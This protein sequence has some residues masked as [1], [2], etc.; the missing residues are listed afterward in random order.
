MYLN[1]LKNVISSNLNWTGNF[2]LDKN[3]ALINTGSVLNIWGTVGRIT[4]L[5]VFQ[6]YV[7]MTFLTGILT[8]LCMYS[9]VKLVIKDS[10]LSLIVTVL[11]YLIIIKDSIGRPSPTQLT[12]WIVFILITIIYKQSIMYKKSSF[13]LVISLYLILILSNP[14]YAIFILIYFTFLIVLRYKKSSPLLILNY[15]FIVSLSLIYYLNLE[16]SVKYN[17]MLIRFGIL[18]D[19]FPGAFNLTITLLILSLILMRLILKRQDE[20]YNF[21]FVLIIS[22]L[23]S[24]NSQILTGVFFEAESHFSYLVKTVIAISLVY[25]LNVTKF[26]KL[27]P[28]LL[29]PIFVFTGLFLLYSVASRSVDIVDYTSK[30]KQLLSVL[31]NPKYSESIFLIKGVKNYDLLDYVSL[32][33]SVKPFWSPVIYADPISDQEIL[34]RFSCTVESNYL[35]RNF[36]QDYKPIFAHKYI[37][38]FQRYPKWDWLQSITGGEKFFTI[39]SRIERSKAQDYTFLMNYKNNYCLPNT[40]EYKVDYILDDQLKII[41]VSAY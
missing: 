17:E 36:L 19:R 26:Y 4:N 21:L 35:F 5:D 34:Q 38:E 15:F 29:I 30:E 3:E 11:I 16:S 32:Y 2:A 6:T 39:Q 27:I 12:L 40:F 25:L 22:C 14:F 31:Q 33:T 24:L 10:R 20:T 9:F 23:L 18:N 8:F 1:Q 41:K 13:V 37:N 7:L 28:N